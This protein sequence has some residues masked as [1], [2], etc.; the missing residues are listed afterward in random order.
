MAGVVAVRSQ[1]PS[2]TIEG[3]SEV[4]EVEEGEGVK[5]GV[6]LE[7]DLSAPSPAA[8]V[9]GNALEREGGDRDWDFELP[10][11]DTMARLA[12]NADGDHLMA[13]L[14][15][16]TTCAQW[17]VKPLRSMTVEIGSRQEN[18]F[19]AWATTRIDEASP[20]FDGL[21]QPGRCAPVTIPIPLNNENLK[22][23]TFTQWALRQ[24]ETI[25][26]TGET[27]SN[28][29]SDRQVLE[30]AVWNWNEVVRVELVFA[31]QLDDTPTRLYFS[32]EKADRNTLNDIGALV[33]NLSQDPEPPWYGFI[34]VNIEGKAWVDHK[35]RLGDEKWNVEGRVRGQIHADIEVKVDDRRSSTA[36]PRVTAYSK[37]RPNAKGLA[38]FLVRP[39]Q[40]VAAKLQAVN[41][42]RPDRADAYLRWVQRARLAPIGSGGIVDDARACQTPCALI[43]RATKDTP[44]WRRLDNSFNETGG[45][46]P[47]FRAAVRCYDL[48]FCGGAPP[49]DLARD[50]VAA[51]RQW[52]ANWY[53]AGR[54]AQVR[55]K[56]AVGA[57]DAL[58]FETMGATAAA[59]ELFSFELV[60]ARRFMKLE[61]TQLLLKGL[62]PTT[63]SK[64]GEPTV[65]VP[66]AL[67]T[68]TLFD[69]ER[70]ANGL[71][72]SALRSAAD[73]LQ[74]EW[75]LLWRETA[76]EDRRSTSPPNAREWLLSNADRDP[77]SLRFDASAASLVC[78]SV[79]VLS[80]A[81]STT[82]PWE[83][84]RADNASLTTVVSLLYELA[85]RAA[86][87]KSLAQLESLSMQTL[88]APTLPSPT[89]VSTSLSS[90]TVD[91]Y[92]TGRR[93]DDLLSAAVAKLSLVDDGV[94]RAAS[95]YG[96]TGEAAQAHRARLLLAREHVVQVHRVLRVTVP[97]LWP[98][99]LDSSQPDVA[100]GR[101]KGL[102][103]VAAFRDSFPILFMPTDRYTDLEWGLDDV[104]TDASES[105]ELASA[106][107]RRSGVAPSS[108]V[109]SRLCQWWDAA[110]IRR[111]RL[112]SLSARHPSFLYTNQGQA[113]FYAPF[114][115]FGQLPLQS[116]L[117][118]AAET[119]PFDAIGGAINAL[120]APIHSP[121]PPMLE[122][123]VRG[124]H[125]P[126]PARFGG[127]GPET[128]VAT[129][130][131]PR[132]GESEGKIDIF[133]RISGGRDRARGT[134]KKAASILW[135]A[136]RLTQAIL[137]VVAIDAKARGPDGKFDHHPRVKITF[138][139]T[140]EEQ[141][142]PLWTET[143]CIA[144]AMAWRVVPTGRVLFGLESPLER[145]KGLS[146]LL[147]APGVRRVSERPLTIAQVIT[148]VMSIDWIQEKVEGGPIASDGVLAL[149]STLMFAQLPAN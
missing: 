132:G 99:V 50:H 59:A 75:G 44:S 80:E 149:L 74:R 12:Y 82:P 60:R 144:V 87:G 54:A 64:E 140:D 117:T 85:D 73:V 9:D 77:L 2:D 69:S 55:Q 126:S 109:L 58:A 118:L 78:R 4:E 10:V 134:T 83:W 61:A 53:T 28:A 23:L 111:D 49:P 1:N 107:G 26:Q 101:R 62:S 141:S 115:C 137:C 66:L 97:M 96:R 35:L 123:N 38:S 104:E 22:R 114:G 37:D 93:S 40:E 94:F 52:Q 138:C 21:C 130:V 34:D 139:T 148:I 116:N 42:D 31:D 36:A 14:I 16:V 13:P 47:N 25:L 56:N 128:I 29:E 120:S 127:G 11:L 122:V 86:H 112:A 110:H 89:P 51:R 125:G 5:G 43:V 20:T 57:M 95:E 17:A 33:Y 15:V 103:A 81:L 3:P 143:V 45:E 46:Q 119:L 67:E 92:V 84:S 91:W 129:V 68:A 70:L 19:T 105:D 18:G 72:A 63:P 48:G 79:P 145:T 30:K 41:V 88:L 7:I 135:N 32:P 39:T 113:T 6:V 146:A 8:F 136:D 27:T 90:A 131:K 108:L 76:T 98:A 102:P 100:D 106:P 133:V 142:V 121:T 71:T 65:S 24:A 147:L 124:V